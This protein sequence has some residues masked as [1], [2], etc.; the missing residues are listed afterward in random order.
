MTLNALDADHLPLVGSPARTAPT[1]RCGDLSGQLLLGFVVTAE[2]QSLS[3]AARTLYRSP[4]ALCR[5]ITH[6][7]RLL[8]HQV[9]V[10]APRGLRLTPEGEALLPQARAALASLEALFEPVTAP[11]VTAPPQRRAPI[12]PLQRLA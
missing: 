8:G 11:S 10:R 12:R 6:L 7:E 4:S 9:F 1:Q 5:Q 2:L 3:A